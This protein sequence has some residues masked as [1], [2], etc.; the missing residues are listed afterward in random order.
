MAMI[1]FR[2]A[3]FLPIFREGVPY[4][5]NMAEAESTLQADMIDS[6]AFN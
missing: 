1:L 3:C 5:K 2:E 6:I 4:L